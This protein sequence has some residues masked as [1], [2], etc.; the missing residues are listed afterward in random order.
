MSIV[1]GNIVNVR[2]HVLATFMYFSH[3]YGNCIDNV[4][5]TLNVTDMSYVMCYRQ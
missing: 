4:S 1:P 5:L 2:V 3:Y